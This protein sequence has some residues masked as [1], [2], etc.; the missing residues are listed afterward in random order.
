MNKKKI[1]LFS[2]AGGIL[3]LLLAAVILFF[4][5]GFHVEMEVQGE[6]ATLEYGTTYEDAG[7]K[8]KN[9]CFI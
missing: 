1:L 2:I 7:A 8:R 4:A 9:K 5:N 3:A 6:N